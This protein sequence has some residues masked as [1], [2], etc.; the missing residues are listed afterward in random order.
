MGP[1]A[2]NGVPVRLSATL[3]D[4]ARKAAA[5]QERSLTEQVEHWARLGERLEATVSSSAVAQ[6]KA[7]S[8]DP[9]L[10]ERIAMAG[11]PEGQ[12]RARELIRSRGGPWYGAAPDDPKVAIRYDT[13]G[14]QTRGRMVNGAFVPITAKAGKRSRRSA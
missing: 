6:V 4:R 5:I 13:D 9:K 11:T 8:H 14:T 12:R 3:A 7:A 2:S 1:M 10:D